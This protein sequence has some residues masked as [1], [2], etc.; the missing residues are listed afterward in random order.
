MKSIVKEEGE[1]YKH[2]A[3]LKHV[4]IYH[5]LSYPSTVGMEDVDLGSVNDPDIVYLGR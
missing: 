3:I 5:E 4:T 2:L 1:S